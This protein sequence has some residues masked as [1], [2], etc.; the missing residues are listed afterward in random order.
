MQT[1]Q[2]IIAPASKVVR[3]RRSVSIPMGIDPKTAIVAI[4]T[5]SAPIAKSLTPNWSWMPSTACDSESRS[6]DSSACIAASAT[7][8]PHP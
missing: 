3:L 1:V 6:P 4:A 2:M 8:G 5:G 7:S